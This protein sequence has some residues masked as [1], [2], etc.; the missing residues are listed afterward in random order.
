MRPAPGSATEDD[1]TWTM[2]QLIDRLRVALPRLVTGSQPRYKVTDVPDARTVRYYIS[3]G[4]VD[5]PGARRGTFA[6]YSRKHLLQILAI[7]KLQAEYLPIRKIETMV[8]GRGFA[9]LE[10]L[11]GGPVDV[12]AHAPGEPSAVP[13]PRDVAESSRA[14]APA[15]RWSRFEVSSGIEL[16]VRE[17]IAP[18]RAE[19]DRIR[20]E[21]ARILK[22]LP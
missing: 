18:D 15:A 14:A 1:A 22:Q 7:K 8:A 13:S 16:H 19:L 6:L 21:I 10:A 4:L 3:L 2:D 17:G 20:I 9:E 5:P 11:V 12:L